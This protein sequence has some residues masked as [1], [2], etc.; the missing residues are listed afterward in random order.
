MKKSLIKRGVIFA[1]CVV[2]GLVIYDLTITEL[3]IYRD[4]A[5]IITFALIIVLCLSAFVLSPLIKHENFKRFLKSAAVSALVAF[6]VESIVFNMKSFSS[7]NEEYSFSLANAV[8]ENPDTISIGESSAN[9]IGYGN[10]IIDLTS[11]YEGQFNALQLEFEGS[12]KA[13][14]DCE[15]YIND[16]NFTNDFI[17]VGEKK[18]SADYGKCDFSFNT[19]ENLQAVKLNFSDITEPVSLKNAWFSKALPFK[20]SDV[21]FYTLFLLLTIICAIRIFEFHKLAYDN[22][23]LKHRISI[24]IVAAVCS[25]SILCFYNP[26]AKPITYTEGMDVS[27]SDPFVQMFDAVHNG[28]VNIDIEPSEEL[29]AM[30]N[31]YDTSARSAQGVHY[32]WDRAYYNGKYYSYYGIAPVLT[33]YYPYYLI[34]GKLPTTNMASVFFGMLSIIFMF[35][36]IM[37]FIKRFIN[38]PNFLLIIMILFASCF[39]SGIYFNATFS[40]MYALPGISGTCWLMLCLWCGFEACNRHGKKRM[41]GK[42]LLFVASGMTFVLCL[43]SKP[44]RA[45]SALILAPIFLDIIF[46]KK[47]KLKE[48]IISASSFLVPV[49][50]GFGALMAYNYARFDSPFQFGAVYQLT[51]SNVNANGLKLS[52]LPNT[53]IHYFFQS[54]EMTDTFPYVKTSRLSLANCCSYIYSDASL[55]ALNMPLLLAGLCVLPFLLY[56]FKRKKGKK[57][58]INDIEIKKFTYILMFILAVLIAWFNYCVAGS[59][60]SYVCDILPLFTLLAVF[61]L[62]DFQKTRLDSSGMSVCAISIICLLTAIFVLLIMLSFEGSALMKRFPN[63]LSTMEDIVCFWN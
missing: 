37:S 27:Y 14:F 30:E 1:V 50:I 26:D 20:F 61:V 51:V 57:F 63:I 12:S 54:P 35:G 43:A 52:S 59:I 41:T 45:L 13:S 38:K 10:V 62:L 16:G 17:K 48:K 39:A 5:S 2:A 18:L 32:A 11:H 29:L 58:V 33:F 40:D 34:K 47:Y 28:R 21:R 4:S 46:N 7:D 3:T 25:L 19:Y 60:L 42:I 23:N 31:P 22:K 24:A 49:A 15:L 56:S 9:I 8:T 6:A 36:A 55:G 53:M 44:T